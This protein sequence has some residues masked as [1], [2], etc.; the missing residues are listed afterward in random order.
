[1]MEIEEIFKNLIEIQSISKALE[2]ENSLIAEENRRLTFLKGQEAH[3]LAQKK[4]L[5]TEILNL[6]KKIQQLE[7]SCA[8]HEKN[9]KQSQEAEKNAVNQ[10][11]LKRAGEQRKFFEKKN[12]KESQEFF[13]YLEILD[14]KKIEQKEI[15]EFL[16]NFP[17][18]YND[19]KQEVESFTQEKKPLVEGLNSR[20]LALQE[21]LPLPI[22]NIFKNLKNKFRDPILFVGLGLKQSCLG[23][24]SFMERSLLELVHSRKTLETCPHCSRIL[25]PFNH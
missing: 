20:I 8:E 25:I 4:E 6:E 18:T 19:I 13:D 22:Q 1:M 21:E 14:P 2:K 15:Q 7:L 12:Q 16:I 23:C 5:D 3:Q 17:Q 11:E 10:N 24:H 9:I